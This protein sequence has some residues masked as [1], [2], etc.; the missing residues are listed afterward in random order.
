MRGIM[1]CMLGTTH[2]DTGTVELG[3][4]REGALPNRATRAGGCSCEVVTCHAKMDDS[5]STNIGVNPSP[6]N[7][8]RDEVHVVVI[9]KPSTTHFGAGA[10]NLCA[11]H[12]ERFPCLSKCWR[13]S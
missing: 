1:S 8:F 3:R 13:Q 5:P 9:G 4:V 2:S 6:L 7:V 10:A 12:V 11:Q